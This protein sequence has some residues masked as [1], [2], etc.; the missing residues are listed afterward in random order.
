MQA[1][2]SELKAL[3]KT[4][5]VDLMALKEKYSQDKFANRANSSSGVKMS[6]E[7]REA[8]MAAHRR[9]DDFKICLKCDGQGYIKE[10][11]NHQM[12]EKT[13]PD[14]DGESLLMRETVARE[15]E[16]LGEIS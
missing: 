4:A 10:M 5:G 3:S 13:C 12:R 6:E 15:K 7:E 1:T 9:L 8:A 14:C 16:K 2:D 11:Y